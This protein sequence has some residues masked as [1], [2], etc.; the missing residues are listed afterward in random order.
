MSL[1]ERYLF[2]GH[3]N[4]MAK[5]IV[6]I[7][8][9][10]RSGTSILARIVAS[11]GSMELAYEP[12][13]FMLL[14]VLGHD[15]VFKPDI[16]GMSLQKCCDEILLHSLL[17]R[18][19]NMRPD[20]SSTV[21]NFLSRKELKGRWKHLK[22]RSDAMEYARKNHTSLVIKSTNLQP[23]YPFLLAALPGLKII[24]IVRN[25]I[26]V[27]TSTVKKGW[28]SDAGLEAPISML[29]KV[30][31][32]AQD[33]VFDVPYYFSKQKAEA[34]Q[35][36]SHFGR[37]LMAWMDLIGQNQ[38]WVKR[39]N[40]ASS[41]R[42]YELKYE[43]LLASPRPIVNELAGFL[44]TRPTQRTFQCLKSLRRPE[45]QVPRLVQGTQVPSRRPERQ[46][47]RLVQGTQVSSRRPEHQVPRLVLGTQ[48]PSRRPEHQEIFFKEALTH[49]DPKTLRQFKRLM[50]SHGYPFPVQAVQSQR[51][52]KGVSLLSH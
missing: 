33:K 20:E 7:T 52:K 27:S 42:Y 4:P 1:R 8:G 23:Y 38:K 10:M 18:S 5:R 34:F 24:H 32:D 13:P 35:K 49:L 25:G 36:A 29:S 26:D 21:F 30:V 44:D 50:K 46:V 40:L 9:V 45:H 43:D 11:L 28:Y 37:C 47:P 48:V 3:E 17:G 51:R 22:S 41:E 14:T 15:G 39:L 2:K 31:T 6:L 12:W 19:V 16:A